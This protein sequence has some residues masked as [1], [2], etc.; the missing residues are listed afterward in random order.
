MKITE[1]TL[2]SIVYSG[3]QFCFCFMKLNFLFMLFYATKL[4]FL[5][6]LS[7]S[8]MSVFIPKLNGN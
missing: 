4:M 7:N 6:F 1:E 5:V 2:S 3:I 8:V